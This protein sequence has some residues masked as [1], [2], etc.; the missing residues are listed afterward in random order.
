MNSFL[1]AKI[2]FLL[3][4]IP[5]DSDILSEIDGSPSLRIPPSLVSDGSVHSPALAMDSQTST[6]DYLAA[7]MWLRSCLNRILGHMFITG[8]AYCQPREV[9][10]FISEVSMDIEIWYRSLPLEL[11]FVRDA[12]SFH[13][14]SPF[15]SIRMVS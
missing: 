13:M 14:L 11:Q 2:T 7:N 3:T 10:P 8:Q 4:L 12:R 9:I 1:L 5:G 15:I 6:F